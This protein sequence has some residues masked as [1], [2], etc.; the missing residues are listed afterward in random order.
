MRRL[1]ATSLDRASAAVR[2]IDDDATSERTHSASYDRGPAVACT[3]AGLA[4]VFMEYASEREIARWLYRV[5]PALYDPRF[6]QLAELTV[7]VVVRLLAFFAIPALAIRLLLRQRVLDHGLRVDGL[8]GH[9]GG[10]GLLF[11]LVLP[12]VAL[13]ASR[14]EFSSYYPFYSLASASWCDLAYWELLYALHFIALEFFFRGFWLTACRRSFGS[15]AVYVAVVPYCMIHF[16]KPLLEVVAA[17]PAGIVLGLLAMRA[18]S[19]W[20]GAALHIAVAYSM[21]AL[22]IWKT[23]GLPTRFM[24]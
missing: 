7:W 19:I 20:G 4:L 6:T 8:R 17:I 18:R 14:P 11:A 22:A 13:A 12:A 9:V 23:T 2:A 1:L 5:V 15:Q 3:V 16:T 10:Y 24:R 21:D